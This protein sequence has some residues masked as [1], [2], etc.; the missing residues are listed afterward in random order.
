MRSLFSSAVILAAQAAAD[1]IIIPPINE[2]AD[3]IAIVW[4]H[5]MDCQ[6]S[7][8]VPLAQEV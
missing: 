4:I 6:N 7:A 2:G 5:G 3:D 1:T 8:Y